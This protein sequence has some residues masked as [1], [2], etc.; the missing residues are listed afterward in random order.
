MDTP[1][2]AQENDIMLIYFEDKPLA[3]ARIE[4]ILSDRNPIGIMLNCF[5][6]RCRYRW[7][8]GS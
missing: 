5:F 8:H 4:S 6:F 1:Q 7:L 2:M 3:F